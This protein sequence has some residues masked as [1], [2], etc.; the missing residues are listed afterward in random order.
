M[1]KFSIRKVNRVGFTCIFKTRSTISFFKTLNVNGIL[2]HEDKTHETTIVHKVKTLMSV[3]CVRNHD[4]CFGRINWLQ[5]G[6][7]PHMSK[8][9]VFR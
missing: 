1:A 2:E 7:R 4:S 6:V 8:G 5:V 9:D 3:C